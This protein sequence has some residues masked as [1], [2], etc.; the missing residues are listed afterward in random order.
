M[1]S[2][3]IDLHTKTLKLV[4]IE[5]SRKTLLCF[6]WLLLCLAVNYNTRFSGLTNT[7]LKSD[8]R[9]CRPTWW[10]S[11]K[12]DDPIKTL[13]GT[14]HLSSPMISATGCN[15]SIFACGVI[16]LMI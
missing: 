2:A 9:C 12:P 6:D 7:R 16:I 8:P 15:E 13:G 5:I 3:H 14:V 11:V 10:G 4:D 1:E